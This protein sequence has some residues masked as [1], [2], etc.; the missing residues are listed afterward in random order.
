MKWARL[1]TTTLPPPDSS[2]PRKTIVIARKILGFISVVVV[3]VTAIGPL[4]ASE[5][6]RQ[7]ITLP[8]SSLPKGLDQLEVM[9]ISDLHVNSHSDPALSVLDGLSGS[10]PDLLV[11]A[12]DLVEKDT[13]VPDVARR[14]ERIRAGYGKFVVW[15]NHDAFGPPKD[16][17]PQWITREARPLNTM[18]R[19]LENHAIQ[20][21]TNRSVCLSI[22]GAEI[23]IVG[24]GDTHVGLDDFEQAFADATPERFTILISHNPD[25]ASVLGELRVDVTLSGHTHGGQIVPPIVGPLTLKTRYTLPQPRGLMYVDGRPLVISAGVGT[26]GLPF[27]INAPA[28]VTE[29]R[30]VQVDHKIKQ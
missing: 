3:W 23:Q 28:D 25:A 10:T 1:P 15:G 27:R 2:V 11:V 8:L 14:L 9:L 19:V 17:D 18:A 4:R 26:V 7:A 21:L 20:T 24:I 22:R 12:G 29:L 13:F 5:I 30:L 6:R 16:R